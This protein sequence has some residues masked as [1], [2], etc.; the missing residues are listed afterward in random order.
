[1]ERGYAVYWSVHLHIVVFGVKVTQIHVLF[2]VDIN[3]SFPVQW[4]SILT[5]SIITVTPVLRDRNEG[6]KKKSDHLLQVIS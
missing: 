5:T 2:A 6:N 3:T 1:M 4:K